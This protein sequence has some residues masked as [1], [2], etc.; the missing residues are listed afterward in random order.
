MNSTPEPIP[1]IAACAIAILSIYASFDFS[2]RLKRG[3]VIVMKLW[4]RCNGQLVAAV[5][6]SVLPLWSL[7]F[8]TESG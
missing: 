8:A 4:A 6:E 2:D 1:F 7:F 5:S 3:K